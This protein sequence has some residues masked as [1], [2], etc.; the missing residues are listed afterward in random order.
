MSFGGAERVKGQKMKFTN[1]ERTNLFT[2]LLIGAAIRFGVV[3]ILHIEPVSDFSSY[4]KMATSMLETGHMDDGQGNVAF[5]SAGYPIFLVPFFALFGNSPETAQFTNAMLGVVSILL[6][7]LCAK[8][9]LPS[10]KWAMIPALIW[11]TYPPAILYTEYVAKENLM[12]TLLMAQTLIL[13]KLP[14]SSRQIRLSALFGFIFGFG[15]LVGPAII[16]TGLLIGLV[17]LKFPLRTFTLSEFQWKPVLACAFAC[18]LALTPWLSY[19][20]AKLGQPILNTNGNFNFYL[21]NNPNAKVHFVGIQDTPIGPEWHALREKEGEVKATASL[22]DRAL[23]YIFE[24]PRKTIWL[25]IRKMA[26]FWMPP[27]HEGKGG[28][29]SK[30]EEIVRLIWAAYYT[31]IMFFALLPLFFPRALSRRHLILYGTAILYCLIYGA[32]YVIFRFRL[33]IMPIMSIL[34]VSGLNFAYLW[35]GARKSPQPLPR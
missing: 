13:L 29:Q 33:P 9:V 34:A 26:Y 25:S 3:A 28:N 31:V 22:K 19:T 1:N 5:Y 20:T 30:L 8:Q 24:N 18:V 2:L 27:I 23:D 16:L 35:W 4:M 12:V 21:G 7:Y 11:S 10:W 17:H 14:D 15:L 32:A 6:V